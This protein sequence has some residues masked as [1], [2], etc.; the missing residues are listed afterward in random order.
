MPWTDW[1]G[2]RHETIIGRPVAMHAMRGIS[3]HSNGFHTCRAIHLLQ[4]LL[5]TVD[6]PGRLP[7]QAALSARRAAAPATGG[8]R[9]EVERRCTPLAGMPLGFRP[10]RRI[11]W[12][13]T[14]ARRGASTR[15]IPGRRRSP[16]TAC[17]HTVIRNAWAGDPYPIDTLFL[18]MANMAWNSSMNTVETIAMLTDRNSATGELQDPAHHLFRRLSTPRRWPTPIWCCPTRPISSAGT[19][20][21]CSTGRS[22]MPTA[23]PTRSAIRWSSPTATSGRSRTC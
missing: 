8:P 5:G 6:A 20:S 10:G 12:S 9:H 16:R 18:Y 3:A 19:A 15:P 1:A 14:T 2:R 17:M 21:R 4:M 13:R 11:C 7:L 22:A 23:R